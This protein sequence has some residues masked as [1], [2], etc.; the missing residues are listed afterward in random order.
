MRLARRVVAVLFTLGGLMVIAPVP[1]EAAPGCALSRSGRVYCPGSTV[2]VRIPVRG[3]VVQLTAAGDSTCALTEPGAVYCWAGGLT[4]PS[5][6]RSS[7][8]AAGGPDGSGLD[9]LLLTTVG[10]LLVV[11]GVTLV[12]VGRPRGGIPRRR[13]RHTPPHPLPWVG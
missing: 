1:A 10:I 11:G 5:S 8:E 12:S 13:P 4:A 6:A 2:P 9:P 7:A 3:K